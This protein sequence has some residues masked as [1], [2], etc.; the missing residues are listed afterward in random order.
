MIK[1]HTKPEFAALRLPV[2]TSI[3]NLDGNDMSGMFT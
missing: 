2:C 1:L 3:R